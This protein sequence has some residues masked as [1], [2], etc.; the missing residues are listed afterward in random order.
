MMPELTDELV[1]EQERVECAVARV[2]CMVRVVVARRP[3]TI[4][5]VTLAAFTPLP[6]HTRPGGGSAEE[7]RERGGGVSRFVNGSI[8]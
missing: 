2:A 4:V 8:G 1:V 6:P 3:S 7:G 5:S